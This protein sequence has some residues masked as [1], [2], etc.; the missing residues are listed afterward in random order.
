LHWWIYFRFSHNNRLENRNKW[1]GL[2]NGIRATGNFL[3]RINNGGTWDHLWSMS[4]AMVLNYRVGFSRFLENNVPSLDTGLTFVA[5]LANPFPSGVAT[6]PGSSLGLATFLGRNLN[7]VPLPD[8]ADAELRQQLPVP[9][10][11]G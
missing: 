10:Q 6:P 9:R 7:F 4:P 2:T 8:R 5:N 3:Y 1:S 11:S